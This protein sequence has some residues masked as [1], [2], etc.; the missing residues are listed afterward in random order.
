MVFKEDKMN[1]IKLIITT[2]W[3]N[4]FSAGTNGVVFLVLNFGLECLTYV[5]LRG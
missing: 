2:F 1:L 5:H 4:A 3:K